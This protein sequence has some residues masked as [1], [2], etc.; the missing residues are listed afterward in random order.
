[1]NKIKI[2]GFYILTFVFGVLL[3]NLFHTCRHIQ[4]PPVLNVD[5]IKVVNETIFVKIDS[6]RNEQINKVEEIKHANDSVTL[7]LWYKLVKR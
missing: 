3:S 6:L 1:M 7:E 2:Y 5:S 4:K